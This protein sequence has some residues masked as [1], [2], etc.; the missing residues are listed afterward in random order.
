M[1]LLR[2]LGLA[3]T[4]RVRFLRKHQK[5]A[6]GDEFAFSG[7][8]HPDDDEN[9]EWT[10][11]NDDNVVDDLFTIKS[12]VEDSGRPKRCDKRAAKKNVTPTEEEDEPEEISSAA[13]WFISIV[14][15]WL[16]I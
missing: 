13:S 12:R 2:S 11:G 16:I 3:V 9:D 4:P 6:A 7:A 14:N 5:A 8:V 1:Y 15:Y 10:A